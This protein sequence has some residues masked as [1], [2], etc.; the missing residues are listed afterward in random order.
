MNQPTQ[1][2]VVSERNLS[3]R[4]FLTT[5]S[6]AL[7]GAA[8]S[9]CATTP[10]RPEP[11]IDIHQHVNYSDRPDSVLL[12]HQRAMGITTTI[13]LPAGRPVKRASTHD[14]NSNGL[15]AKAFGNEACYQF[16]RAHPKEFRFAANEVP[17]VEGATAEIEKYLKLGAV[18]IAEQKFGVECDS[19][20]MQRIYELAQ[21]YRVPVL[22][23]WQ[24]QMYNHGFERFYKMLEKYPR[25]SFLGHAQTWWANVDRNYKDDAQNLYPKGPITPGGLTER[26]LADYPNMFGDLSAGS[27]LNALTRDPSFTPGF[28]Q[29]HQ[30]KLIYGSDCNDLFGSGEKCQGAQTIAAIRRFAPSIKIERKL[31]YGNAKKLIR[32]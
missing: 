25:V 14:G 24:F 19:P 3:R 16:A 20:E 21:A 18:M 28:F 22:M 2:R 15:Q 10:G 4:E 31:L 13:L 11:I 32:L 7:A 17:D 23:H 27:G 26:Y 1:D 6:L 29:R 30:D 9:G 12:T 8:L 5:T